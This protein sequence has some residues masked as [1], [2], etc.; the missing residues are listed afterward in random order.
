MSEESHIQKLQP[1]EITT[2]MTYKEWKTIR[3]RVKRSGDPAK[4]VKLTTPEEHLAHLWLVES[5]HGEI[6]PYR[7][8]LHHLIEFAP[9]L[10]CT[11]FN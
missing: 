10:G 2:K 8:R 5:D 11:P 4:G 3:D 9:A 6:W 1:E 7:M